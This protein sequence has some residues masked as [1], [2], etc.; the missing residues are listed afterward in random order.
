MLK[1]FLTPLFCF[2]M[3]CSFDYE[4]V[5]PTVEGP[6]GSFTL[7]PDEMRWEK[8][9]EEELEHGVFIVRYVHR[10]EPIIGMTLY[11]P[12]PRQAIKE[13]SDEDL[14]NVVTGV[15]DKIFEDAF[16]FV[17]KIEPCSIHGRKG[18]FAELMYDVTTEDDQVPYYIDTLL[19]RGENY[20][21]VHLT[22]TF[23]EDTHLALGQDIMEFL[24]ALV[25]HKDEV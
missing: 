18:T 15:F 22:G 24:E 19:Y 5:Q 8:V 12:G 11:A 16:H 13:L 4:L 3:L 10:E 6:E 1:R 25:I 17:N 9:Q 2:F 7:S 21:L 14:L 23:T 20:F